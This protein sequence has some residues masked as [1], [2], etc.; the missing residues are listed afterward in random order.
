MESACEGQILILIPPKVISCVDLGVLAVALQLWG[1]MR[2][3][4]QDAV[5]SPCE[6]IEDYVLKFHLQ[7]EKPIRKPKY[8]KKFWTTLK[9]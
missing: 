8:F 4:E 3:R 5:L 7:E 6:A 2:H 1:R 9:A